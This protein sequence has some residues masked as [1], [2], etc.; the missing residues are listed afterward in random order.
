MLYYQRKAISQELYQWLLKESY[1]DRNLIA[2]W[3]KAGYENLCCLQCIQPVETN[4]FTTCI[5][6]VPIEDR[7]PAK[8]DIE[9]HTCGC[10]GC[11]TVMEK[12]EEDDDE[13]EVKTKA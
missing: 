5:C 3:K 2:K 11:A 4:F 6:R 8:Q 13:E 12:E 7:E 10:R 1:A 9:C